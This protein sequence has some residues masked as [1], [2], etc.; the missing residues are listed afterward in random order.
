VRLGETAAIKLTAYPDRVL[1]GSISNI[2]YILDPN[3]R[4]AKVRL[5]VPNP[6]GMMRP[7]MFATATF[8]SKEK[9]TYTSVPASAILHLHDRDWVFIPAQGKFRRTQVTSGAQ[10]PSQMQEILTGLQPGQQVVSNAGT[11]QNAIDNE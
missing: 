4:T 2:G 11:L 5:E 1:K 6:G 8:F 10:L 7:G 9:H 3:I